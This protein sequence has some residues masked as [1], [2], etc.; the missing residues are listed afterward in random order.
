MGGLLI[1]RNIVYSIDCTE[2]SVHNVLYSQYTVN[3]VHNI[4]YSQYTVN[5]DGYLL[6]V[7]L[8][9][10]KITPQDPPQ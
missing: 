9:T 2:Y 10:V 8:V 6:L 3:T 5:R 7:A 1:V 4:L